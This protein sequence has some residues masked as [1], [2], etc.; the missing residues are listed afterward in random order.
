MRLRDILICCFCVALA[1]GLFIGSASQLDYINSR[2]EKLNL[3][4]EKPENLPPSLAFATVATGA[5]RS[6]VVD[7]LWIRAE[8]LK[9]QKQ[10]FDAK[11]L[12]E[13]ITVL[14][15]RFAAVWEFQAW[16]MAY[17]ISVAIP[18]SQ[19]E[20]RWRWVKN[21]F[22]LLRDTAIYKYKLKN[23]EIYRQIA[24]IFQHKM[25][26]MSDED[27][28][29]YKL[30]LAALMEPLLGPADNKFFD[31]LTSAPRNWQEVSADPAV[32]GFINALKQ[33]SNLF[34]NEK[35][36]INNY[37]TIQADPNAPQWGK[38]GTVLSDYKN[39]PAAYKFYVFACAWQLRNIWKLDPEL[40]REINRIYGPIDWNDPNT[41]L[42]L[43]WRHP[44]S[45]AIYWAYQGIQADTTK[46]VEIGQTNT[47]RIIA[48]SLQNLFRYGKIFIYDIVQ[49]VNDP[50]RG[51]GKQVYQDIFLRH[52]L[53]IFEPYNQSMLAIIEKYKN[54]TSAGSLQSLKDGHRNMLK[55]AVLSF[56]QAGHKDKA[57]KIYDELRKLYPREEFDVPLVTYT[58]NR[59]IDE[60]ARNDVVNTQEQ[61]TTMLMETYYL[62]AI[63]DDEET[64]SRETMAEEI[65]NYY[66]NEYKGAQ[67]ISLPKDFNMLRS[68][69]MKDF[70]SS[71][72]FPVYIRQSLLYRM[73]TERPD[74]YNK[75]R[76]EL[77]K[78][79]S[80]PQD[81]QPKQP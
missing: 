20:Q 66:Q 21:G 23:P 61:L 14:Q 19:Y 18:D 27:H 8:N 62:Y 36:F 49:D 58:R 4:F 59:L 63:G 2:R 30:Q 25:G 24:L 57:Q 75:L 74:L 3:V 79:L 45:H 68:L 53:R 12:A 43:D 26:G 47:D 39:T 71:E 34:S 81:S 7:I 11:Q 5:F 13:W 73:M 33:A 80:T 37:F 60:L 77:E 52:D 69:A 40:M 51:P 56:Y 46:K 54:D 67:R 41:H 6:L 10:F 65:Y 50:E 70:L 15:P 1:A 17:N 55:N 31:A 22:E 72:L 48:N 28:K 78:L 44:D 9:E 16:N 35:E 38:A 29:Y 64:L 76:P 42:P 32:A